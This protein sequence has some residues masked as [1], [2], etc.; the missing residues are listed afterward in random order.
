MLGA[1]DLFGGSEVWHD[2]FKVAERV[3]LSAKRMNQVNWSISIIG[4]SL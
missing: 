4:E 2:T 3:T 1:L